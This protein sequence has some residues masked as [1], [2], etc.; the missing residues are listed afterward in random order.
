VAEAMEY[1]KFSFRIAPEIGTKLEEEA[2][3]RDLTTSELVREIVTTH[4]EKSAAPETIGTE[5]AA[6]ADAERCFQQLV[7]EIGKTRS[8]VL[9]IG[10]QTI[11]EQT[12]EQILAAATDDAKDYAALVAAGMK[13][14]TAEPADQGDAS[15]R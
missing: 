6:S 14:L 5:S 8:A 2:T 12:M 3:K 13:G 15:G 11:P 9:R 1:P 10:L 7:F 4:Y